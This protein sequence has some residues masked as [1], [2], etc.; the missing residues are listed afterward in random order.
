MTVLVDKAK[1]AGIGDGTPESVLR[2]L[3]KGTNMESDLDEGLARQKEITSEL[4]PW[5]KTSNISH[6]DP[7][8]RGVVFVTNAN[9]VTF[10]IRKESRSTYDVIIYFPRDAQTELTIPSKGYTPNK[11]LN[12]DE[13]KKELMDMID[14]RVL[15]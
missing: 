15:P 5:L 11:K 7:T 10:S 1:Q 14:Y 2:V 12:I 6:T 13:L 9:G 8:M 3:L 4:V